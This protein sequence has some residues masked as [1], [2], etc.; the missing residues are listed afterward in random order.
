[1]HVITAAWYTKTTTC[2]YCTIVCSNGSQ[3]FLDH[4]IH[5]LK[6]S[7]EWNAWWRSPICKKTLQIAYIVY[8]QAWC[9]Y[10]SL[11]LVFPCPAIGIWNHGAINTCKC[12]WHNNY[13]DYFGN[14]LYISVTTLSAFAYLP[15]VGCNPVSWWMILWSTIST[16]F[17]PLDKHLPISLRSV[18][19]WSQKKCTRS[20]T[21][22]I[23]AD[24][25][26][27]TDTCKMYKLHIVFKHEGEF[28]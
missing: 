18:F 2:M 24:L 11:E 14:E 21:F 23:T 6:Y 1:M 19:R 13:G 20:G 25:I 15:I 7:E 9:Q 27:W 17:S 4:G 22:A 10:Q 28:V 3:W 26:T 5:R 8:L 16:S 12:G